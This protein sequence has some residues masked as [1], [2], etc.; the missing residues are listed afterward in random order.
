M[1]ENNIQTAKD[2]IVSCFT[3]NGNKRLYV[4]EL[5]RITGEYPNSVSNA[6]KKLTRIGYVEHVVVGN[7]SYYTL[8]KKGQIE[9]NNSAN[10]NL[11]DKLDWVKLL[12]RK[13]SCSFNAAVSE[14]NITNL[15]EVYAIK[16]PTFWCNGVT[17]GVYYSRTEL[18]KLAECISAKIKDKKEF[19]KSDVQLCIKY[20]KKLIQETDKLRNIDLSKLTTKEIETLFKNFYKHYL[21][22]MS[23]IV[24][25]HSI[26][27]YFEDQIKLSVSDPKKRETLLT[28][29]S[30]ELDELESVMVL[31]SYYKNYGDDQEYRKLLQKHTN[32]YC[33]LNMWDIED[34]PLDIEYFDKAIREI[35][36]SVKDPAKEIKRL[37]Q[38]ELKQKEHLENTLRGL[39]AS[40]TLRDH[41]YLL[42]KYIYL[43]TYRKN[44]ISKAHYNIK[45]LLSEISHRLRIDNN[46]LLKFTYKEILES[47]KSKDVRNYYVESAKKRKNGWAVL[48]IGG[49]IEIISGMKDVVESI[50]KYSIIP[51]P[52]IM[53]QDIITGRT[54]QQGCV[55]G[56]AKIIQSVK[57]LSKI[58]SGDILITKMTTPDFVVAMRKCS[59][60]V[61]DEGGITCHAAIVSR[62]LGVPCIVGV[63]TATSRIQDGYVV[64]LNATRGFVRVLRK[65]T[66][67]EITDK[68]CGK[69]IVAGDVRGIATIVNDDS[70]VV[71]IKQGTIVVASNITPN[72]LSALFKTKGI[73][74]EEDSL[75]SHG[76]LYAKALK[77]PCIA[78]VLDARSIIR[79]GQNIELQAGSGVIKIGTK[80]GRI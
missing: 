18:S 17:Y 57:E 65:S 55:T 15:H 56:T 69:S 13:S 71:K 54:A 58:E 31:A 20:C 41:V 34:T 9:L 3:N 78:G 10:I 12:N 39:K 52:V 28:P 36:E 19:A 30:H 24:V 37:R 16:I 61:T 66:S 1:V 43:R 47:F 59:G 23:F 2:K 22:L 74:L 42:Q 29:A 46:L 21:N 79:E 76:T 35:S 51:A 60:I 44:S 63:K 49:K 67:T 77:I 62:E 45:P 26:E 72:A 5:I 4:N 70:D 64:E 75:T 50:E 14:A 73:I 8:S 68:L 6:L 27:R 80:R 53:Q 25:P 11:H 7:K 33:W 40:R 48:M 32:N 38:E